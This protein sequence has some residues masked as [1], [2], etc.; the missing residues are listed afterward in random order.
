MA[1][2]AA[3][4]EIADWYEDQFLPAQAD[5]DPLGIHRA[6]VTL[7]GP[8]PGRC[9]EIGCGTGV[10]AEPL[11]ALGWTP[12]GVDLSAGMLRHARGR[13][14][15]ARA[16]AARL[17]VR[18]GSLDAVLTV[19]AHTD[20]SDYPAVLR[21]AARILRPGGTFVHIGVHPAFCGG[22]ADR[23]DPEAVVI[24]P[25]YLDGH[26]TKSS[27]TAE[28]VRDKV[29]AT[30]LPLPALLHAFLDAGLTLDRF[31]EGAAPTP[32]VLGVRATKP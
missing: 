12:I 16:D 31:A 5:G 29:G 10:Y 4:D 19:M 8:G 18:D 25:G 28:G 7:L 15:I 20:F 9:L 2:T 27:W 21:E 13:L 32:I 30:H 23:A 3:Y 17:P 6:L 26:W 11:R 1:P 22:F 24:R 14:P